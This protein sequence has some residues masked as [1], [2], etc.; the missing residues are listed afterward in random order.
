MFVKNSCVHTYT[1][2]IEALLLWPGDIKSDGRNLLSMFASRDLNQPWPRGGLSFS[3]S[4]RMRGLYQST[5]RM[6]SVLYDNISMLF[7]FKTMH[8]S[9]IKFKCIQYLVLVLDIGIY[10]Y[11]YI[12]LVLLLILFAN[13]IT[14]L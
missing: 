5:E 14:Y 2:Y 9:T 3:L 13:S 12:L 1:P 10:C 6:I 8:N 4:E 11:E 7:D